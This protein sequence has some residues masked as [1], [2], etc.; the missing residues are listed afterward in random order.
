MD[1]HGVLGVI[2][3]SSDLVSLEPVVGYDNK[4]SRDWYSQQLDFVNSCLE[5][6]S[7]KKKKRGRGA[8]ISTQAPEGSTES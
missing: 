8:R 4:S 3:A 5:V 2:P 7:R 1:A 6:S